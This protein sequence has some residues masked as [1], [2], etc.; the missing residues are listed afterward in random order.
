MIRLAQPFYS[1]CAGKSVLEN[2]L[3]SFSSFNPYYT[4]I[5]S[6]H[7]A[8]IHLSFLFFFFLNKFVG[9]LFVEFVA[10]VLSLIC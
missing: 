9:F 7:G 1:H 3:L 6:I 8:R 4:S 10:K 5:F 2:G